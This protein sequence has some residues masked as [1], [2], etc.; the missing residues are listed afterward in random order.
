MSVDERCLP[1][2][3]RFNSR[4]SSM[5]RCYTVR[6][7]DSVIKL[8]T[9][10]VTDIQSACWVSTHVF[11]VLGLYMLL[12]SSRQEFLATDPNVPCSIPGATRFSEK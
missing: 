7:T 12:W 8:Q 11:T 2:S 5:I 6:I 1:H 9:V 4:L 10:R 3:F